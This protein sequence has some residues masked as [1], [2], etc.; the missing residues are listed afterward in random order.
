[1]RVQLAHGMEQRVQ[2]RTAELAEA[3]FE[4]MYRERG[5]G[6]AAVQVGRLIRMFIT[7]VPS[8]EPRVFINPEIV[9]TSIEEWKYEEG[10]LSI[11]GINADDTAGRRQDPG[12]EPAWEDLHP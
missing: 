5:I 8:D 3:M 6:L 11:P 4:T 10:C 9:G 12:H 2:Q 7:H 1:M